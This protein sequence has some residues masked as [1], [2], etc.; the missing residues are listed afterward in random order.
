MRPTLVELEAE[1][2]RGIPLQAPKGSAL[3]RERNASTISGRKGRYVDSLHV[4]TRL[5][6]LRSTLSASPD[7]RVEEGH[8]SRVGPRPDRAVAD[9]L[10]RVGIEHRDARRVGA[11]QAGPRVCSA[12]S[13]ATGA[14][15]SMAAETLRPSVCGA[16]STPAR[17]KRAHCR[18]MGRCSMNLSR[19]PRR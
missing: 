11:E 18:S 17:A 10:G 16:T 13:R 14:S 5:D 4:R 15:K 9:A 2:H 19:Q 1:G 12:M 8:P 7:G 6:L 3:Q